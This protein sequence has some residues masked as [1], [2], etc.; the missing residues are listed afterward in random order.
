VSDLIERLIERYELPPTAP[1]SNWSTSR[2]AARA[3][4]PFL[5]K[6]R[7]A[8]Y[9]FLYHEGPHA[10]WQIYRS[11]NIT[12]K[13]VNSQ[14]VTLRDAGLV[15]DSGQTVIKPDSGLDT[16]LW[17]V[18]PLPDPDLFEAYMKAL[19]DRK[20][21]VRMNITVQNCPRP[22]GVKRAP[23]TRKLILGADELQA[24]TDAL[25]GKD[26]PLLYDL[27]NLLEQAGFEPED[28]EFGFTDWS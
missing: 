28:N 19:A 25:Q 6:T 3:I 7:R 22:P 1:Y 9:G 12:E 26:D 8:I 10:D 24:L 2:A 27:R 17:E 14:R 21:L 13:T 18:V 16:I 20:N 4:E 23:S 5:N 11:T 15:R